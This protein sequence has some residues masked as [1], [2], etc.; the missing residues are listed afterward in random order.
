MITRLTA[1]RLLELTSFLAAQLTGILALSDVLANRVTVRAS[2]RTCLVSIA[3]RLLLCGASS[4]A[5]A[6]TRAILFFVDFLQSPALLG[7]EIRS[8]A[9]SASLSLCILS[10]VALLL[11]CTLLGTLRGSGSILGGPTLCARAVA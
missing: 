6:G 7:T 10:G 11:G 5:S 2:L 3:L 8:R 9:L 4:G 1:A